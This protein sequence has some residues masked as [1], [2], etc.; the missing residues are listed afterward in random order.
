MSTAAARDLSLAASISSS[1]GSRGIW[2]AI[3]QGSV[4]GPFFFD[5]TVNKDRYL[6][7]LQEEFW[8]E[9]EA[10]DRTGSILFMQDGAAPH[11]GIPVMRICRSDG[12]VVV[13][14]ICLG[15]LVH[16]ISPL[17]IFL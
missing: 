12:W 5:D 14:P 15:P 8:P 6:K 13:H 17:S 1:P 4:Y 7:M 9:V 3:W 2:A 10:K 11:W 16:P